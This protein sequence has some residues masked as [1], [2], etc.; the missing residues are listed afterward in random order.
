MTK[1]TASQ[2]Q[3]LKAISSP[4]YRG[5]HLVIIKNKVFSAQTGQQAVKLFKE[6]TKKYPKEKPTI[7]YVPKEEALIL[8]L[9]W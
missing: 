4:R 9:K 5:R 3:I 8:W 6:V 1:Q 7:T 2:N